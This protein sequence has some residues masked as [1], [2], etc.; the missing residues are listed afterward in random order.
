MEFIKSNLWEIKK[1]S[2]VS[3]FGA[4]VALGH[5]LI[6]LNWSLKGSL[7]LQFAL[8]PSPMCWP[9][10][11][12][13]DFWLALPPGL[14]K[15]LYGGYV[16]FAASAFL[17]FLFSRLTGIA[18]FFLSLSFLCFLTLYFRDYRLSSNEHYFWLLVTLLYL[19][20][21]N[22]INNLRFIIISF[23][24]ALALIRLKPEWMTGLWILDQFPMPVKLAEWIAALSVLILLVIPFGLLF[25]DGRYVTLSTL[26][27]VGLNVFFWILNDFF[28]P[29]I[30]LCALSLFILHWLEQRKLERDYIYQSFIRPEPSKI[31]VILV[32]GLFWLGQVAP[33]LPY[34]KP[35]VRVFEQAVALTPLQPIEECRSIAFANYENGLRQIHHTLSDNTTGESLECHPQYSFIEFRRM[36]TQLQAET[37]TDNALGSF[38]SLSVVFYKRGF[39]DIQFQKVYE[40]D[41]ICQS[42]LTLTDVMGDRRGL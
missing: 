39:K 13:C 2:A 29:A 19:F 9:F 8:D 32:L 26:L 5:I 34:Q 25:R 1:S 12:N 10:F 15:F 22:K 11:S 18:W 38:E 31:W 33:F 6:F 23:W 24:I 40:A 21:P 42:G 7:P 20:V 36:C 3:T 28:S 35:W 17:I 30:H 41:D 16:F 14:L 27:L 37:E 4:A